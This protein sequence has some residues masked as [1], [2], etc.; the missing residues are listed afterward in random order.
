ME[1]MILADFCRED[2]KLVQREPYRGTLLPCY[3][4]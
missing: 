2:R 3:T 4:Q 1:T